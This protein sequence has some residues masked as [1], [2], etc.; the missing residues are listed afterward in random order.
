MGEQ[1]RYKRRFLFWGL[2]LLGLAALV[3]IRTE[4]ADALGGGPDAFGYNW[5]DEVTYLYEQATTSANMG[6]DSIYVTPIGFDFDLYGVTYDEVTLTSEGGLHFDGEVA[7]PGDNESLPYTEFTGIFPF[8][9]DMNL[10][11]AG[12][13]YY[14]TLGIAPNRV[15]IAEWRGAA[16]MTNVAPYYY[17]GNVDV[18]VK[19]FEVDDSIEFHYRDVNFGDAGYDGGASAT[20]GIVDAVQGYYLMV[21]HNTLSLSDDYAIRFEPPGS[22]VD[23]DGDGWT[24]CDGDCDDAD[25]AIHPGAAETCDDGIDSNCDG[26][27]DE[28]ADNDADGFTN[29]D[30]D[31][32]D[33]E[34]Q[35][36]PGNPEQCDYIDNDCD[37]WADNG[38]DEDGDGWSLC[39]GDCDDTNVDVY[40]SAYEECDGIDSDCMD[41][42]AQTEVDD[43]GD[44]LSECDGDCHDGNAAIY[45]G[46]EE[47]CDTLDN[48]CD[49][50]TDENADVDLDNYSICQGDCND[51]D[52]GMNPAETEV[53]DKK[54][55]DCN[56]VVD[57]NIDFDHDGYPGCGGADCD[58]YNA[59]TNPGSTEIPYDNIDQDCSGEDLTDMDGDGYDGGAYGEDC[60]DTNAAMN[61][62]VA[63]DCEN[64]Y[65]DD[66]DGFTDA[67]DEDCQAGDDDDATGGGGGG[68]G[69]ASAG[70]APAHGAAL[71]AGLIAVAALRR[72][73]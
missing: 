19:L 65:D 60:D 44:G 52:A 30:G 15:F 64:S 61:P 26:Q 3:P 57:D 50:E 28:Q 20:I 54:D 36:F 32:D 4:R 63:E 38:F 16:H 8:W 35:A 43:D 9:D 45:P 46:A 37:G 6:N 68:C 25:A 12:Q 48:D 27:A 55:N 10:S 18:E 7:L 66:C 11:G 17:I 13:V 49:P 69:C 56:G 73:P 23:D 2:I 53:C 22:C 62:G 42:L 72:R 70:D 39:E 14:E 5:H 21:S 24:Q 58:D 40:P 31:C 67:D 29:C 51:G 47:T 71:L 59:G 33:F 41:D 34:P 1:I